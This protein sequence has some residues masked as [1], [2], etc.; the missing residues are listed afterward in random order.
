KDDRDGCD[1][2]LQRLA[3]RFQQWRRS[4]GVLFRRGEGGADA[5][6]GDEEGYGEEHRY[7]VW[8]FSRICPFR[9]LNSASE[10]AGS[11]PAVLTCR[12][13]VTQDLQP[14]Y[15]ARMG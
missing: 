14:A 6:E 9:S 5:G 15:S 10:S 11:A 1:E 8:S 13:S 12:S 2:D 4:R 7:Q 3:G